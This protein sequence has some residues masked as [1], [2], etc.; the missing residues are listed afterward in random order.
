MINLQSNERIVGMS[1]DK[2]SP[3]KYFEFLTIKS[4][5]KKNKRKKQQRS[6]NT[7]YAFLIIVLV[8]VLMLGVY[9]YR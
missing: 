5:I 4:G 8:F 3:M 2:D 1:F 9:M 6:Y 7:V